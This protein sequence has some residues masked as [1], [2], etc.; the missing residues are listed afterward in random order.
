MRAF[1]VFSLACLL[2]NVGAFGT[3]QSKNAMNFYF[4]LSALFPNFLQIQL[5]HAAVNEESHPR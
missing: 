1:S 2:A 4:V 3:F 5:S